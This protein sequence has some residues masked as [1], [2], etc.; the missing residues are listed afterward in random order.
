MD[1]SSKRWRWWAAA[2]L[3]VLGLGA[4]YG[5]FLV[6][7][8]VPGWS[9]YVAMSSAAGPDDRRAAHAFLDPSLD[10]EHR[11]DALFAYFAEG[12]LAARSADGARAF[13]RG[14]GSGRGHAVSGLEGFARTAPL[15]GAWIHSGRDPIFT[16]PSTGEKVDLVEV[17]RAGLL[18]GTDP[19]APSYWGDMVDLD[20]KIVEAADIARLLWLTRARIWDRASD[21][22]KAQIADWLAQADRHRV[23]NNNWL[24]FSVVVDV[25]LDALGYRPLPDQP[26][27]AAFKKYH[28]QSGWFFDNPEGVDYYNAWGISYDLFWIHLMNGRFDGDFLDEALKQSAS[29][30]AHLI[31]PAGVPIL[32]RSV[33]YRT[34][35]PAPV[36]AATFADAAPEVQGTGVRALDAVWRYFVANDVLR[37]G[38]LTLGYFGTDPRVVDPYTG[39]GS[40]HWG[41]RSLMLAYMHPS[42]GPFWTAAATPLPV[43]VADYVLDLPELGWVVEGDSKSLEI[44]IRVVRN[45]NAVH[46]LK[47]YGWKNELLEFVRRKPQRPKNHAAKYESAVYSSARPFPLGGD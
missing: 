15:L 13:Y 37:D 25:A 28:L 17:L 40:C 19:K 22:E 2:G 7:S 23:S 16:R 43:E 47:P 32:G 27:Y 24:L 4:V 12:F 36:I 44:R 9:R 1:F 41:L 26:R 21:E 39:S 11:Y 45:A 38:A 35:I 5:Y 6:K 31:S 20:Q 42:R 30:T 3:I 18:A 8:S 14:M 46:G 34:A 29:L 33:C 10:V